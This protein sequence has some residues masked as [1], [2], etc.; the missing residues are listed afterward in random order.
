[1]HAGGELGVLDVP[2]EVVLLAGI[3]ADDLEVKRERHLGQ[4]PGKLPGPD[5]E[6]A[7]PWAEHRAHVASVEL[8]GLLAAD[9]L[10]ANLPGLEIQRAADELVARGALQ[11][12]V[13]PSAVE[14][15]LLY[16]AQGAAAGEAEAGG[17]L[18]AYAVQDERGPGDPLAGADPFDQVV[19]AATPRHRAD[20]QAIVA[21]GEQ[22]A[23]RARRRAPCLD[24]RDQPCVVA[25]GVPL[26]RLLQYLSVEA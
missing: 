4:R 22:R 8:E 11:Q 24:D 21:D 10:E 23:R 7:P 14:Q 13:D 17:F 19:L 1:G 15:G 18:L 6:H 26:A 5:D 3:A 20:H 9:R 16:E 25:G 2:G 12:L